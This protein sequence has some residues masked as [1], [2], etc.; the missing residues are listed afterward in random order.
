MPPPALLKLS[1]D[2]VGPAF[3]GREEEQEVVPRGR[4]ILVGHVRRTK[5]RDIHRR[6]RQVVPRPIESQ[7]ALFDRRLKKL[8][9]GGP[10]R[11]IPREL[12]EVAFSRS[13]PQ[14][15]P[16]D[17]F[18]TAVGA[19]EEVRPERFA[20][21]D[22]PASAGTAGLR[23]F[24]V[25]EI[26]QCTQAVAMGAQPYS[27]ICVGWSGRGWNLPAATCRKHKI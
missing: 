26:E 6:F 12:P 4:C 27:C 25:V 19:L 14:R 7:Q 2:D 20:M 5:E 16:I 24:C 21:R 11:S 1:G 23:R 17:Q 22:H 13:D 9:V 10:G 8:T 3:A 18:E 15:V